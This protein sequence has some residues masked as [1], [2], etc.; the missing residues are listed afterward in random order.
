[1]KVLLDNTEDVMNGKTILAMVL[2]VF[3]I[4]SIMLQA[5][6]YTTNDTVVDIGPI[7]A[8]KSEHHTIS[9]PPVIGVIALLGGVLVLVSSRRSTAV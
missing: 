5:V 6:T 9:L 4:F 3:V 7:Q 2:I 1:M 8:S